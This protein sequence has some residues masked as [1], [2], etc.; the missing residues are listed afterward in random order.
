MQAPKDTGRIHLIDDGAVHL[1]NRTITGR[2]ERLLTGVRMKNNSFSVHCDYTRNTGGKK[3]AQQ[4][5]GWIHF[6]NYWLEPRLSLPN[7]YAHFLP[8]IELWVWTRLNSNW[9][10]STTCT[11]GPWTAFP[12]RNLLIL[13]ITYCRRRLASAICSGRRKEAFFCLDGGKWGQ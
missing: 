9:D 10:E 12:I 11:A 2:E 3:N 4:L 7:H 8:K 1:W 13:I 5:P 6:P